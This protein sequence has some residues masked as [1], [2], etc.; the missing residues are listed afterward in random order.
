VI[1]AVVLIRAEKGAVPELGETIAAVPG[2]SEVYSVTGD[3]DLIAMVR[4]REHEELADIVTRRPYT[5][6]QSLLDATQP[7]GR[8]YYWKSHYLPEVDR[9][10]V[11]LAAEHAGR[12]ASPHSA[13]L[14]FQIGGAL[15]EL[16][17]AHS[18]AANRDA[19]YVLNIA[20][21]WEAPGEDAAHVQWARD[22]F[23][24]TRECSTG[25]V[26]INFLTEE[27]GADRIQAAYG[28]AGL[29]KLATLLSFTVFLV[30]RSEAPTAIT[31]GSE[32][33]SA[34]ELAAVP[35]LPPAAT[36]TMPFRQAT[37]AA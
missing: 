4:A 10:M 36:T 32:A 22:C 16:P 1:T 31:N 29:E 30:P 25:G 37:S 3:I 27:E 12:I 19:T 5:Q 21:S 2:V 33:G 13:I 7:K 34:S 24:A 17:A 35:S 26:Y 6:M 20:A 9:R 15:N 28:S 14:L 11:E 23:E 18:P 8:R